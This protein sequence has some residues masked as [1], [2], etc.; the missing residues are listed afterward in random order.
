MPFKIS[1]KQLPYIALAIV[2][3]GAGLYFLWGRPA[4]DSV[5]TA[6]V[7]PQSSQ[8]ATFLGLATELDAVTLD[9]GI[10]NDPRFT[11]LKDIHTTI[12]SEPI[13]RRDPFANLPGVTAA[14]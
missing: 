1:R 14:P 4:S 10:F 6:D 9:S 3:V 13:G 7:T 2:V 5:V 11:T 8:E 12:I